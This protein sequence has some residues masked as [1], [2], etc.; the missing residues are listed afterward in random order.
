MYLMNVFYD[1][2]E[3]NGYIMWAS[4]LLIYFQNFQWCGFEY[5]SNK[6]AS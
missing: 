6:N 2:Y 5:I 3:D 1:S 4:Y